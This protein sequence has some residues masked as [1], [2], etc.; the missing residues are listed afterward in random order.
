MPMRI[1][2]I[3]YY[4]PNGRSADEIAADTL[5]K[6]DRMRALTAKV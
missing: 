5:V 4:E 3:R 1:D 6:Y 2:P